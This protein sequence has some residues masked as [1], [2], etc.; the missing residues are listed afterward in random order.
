MLFNAYCVSG[1]LLNKRDRNREESLP[2]EEFTNNK[3][4]TDLTMYDFFLTNSLK[5]MSYFFTNI[6]K[7]IPKIF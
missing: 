3:R 2:T 6:S 7:I 5:I 1:P 4:F